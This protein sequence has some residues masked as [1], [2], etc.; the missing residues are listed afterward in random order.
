MIVK[1]G[2][3]N[4]LTYTFNA[5]AKTISATGLNLG[6]VT[7]IRNVTRGN[8]EMKG[9]QT[10]TIVLYGVYT[11]SFSE[12][13]IDSLNTDIID[14]MLYVDGDSEDYSDTDVL[15]NKSWSSQKIQSELLEI[16]E[17]AVHITGA[18]TI[19]GAKTFSDNVTMNGSLSGTSLS[20]SSSGTFIGTVRVKDIR[21][22]LVLE[23]DSQTSTFGYI[24][25]SPDGVRYYTGAGTHFF[26]QP[27]YAG[28]GGGTLYNSPSL[29]IRAN[30]ATPNIPLQV[31]SDIGGRILRLQTYDYNNSDTG[32][33]LRANFGAPTGNTH[34]TLQ[35]YNA[36]ESL[37][38][39]LALNPSGGNVGIGIITPAYPL[40]V[41]G[42]LGAG[43][44]VLSGSLAQKSTGTAWSNP[45]D[46]RLKDNIRDYQKGTEELMKVQVREWEYNGKGGTVL[47]TRGLGV[48]ADD[49][50]KVLP[51]TVDTYDAKLNETDEKTTAIKK[52]DASEITWLLVK[53]VQEQQAIITGLEKR[54]EAL[55]LPLK[56]KI[57]GIYTWIKSLMSTI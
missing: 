49:V 14:I 13:P 40:Q 51:N 38:G 15:F 11:L 36:G 43:G 31:S 16:A 12:V 28:T 57:N 22:T 54:I 39:I 23:D 32:S 47:G 1:I 20:M 30:Q 42:S 8:V 10:G 44:I 50:M 2:V 27:I 55:E 35:S 53:T 33:S 7:S 29:Y 45:S 19:A 37:V 46:S 48:I 17:D 18:E 21:P 41:N 4:A 3:N 26:E 5:V 56:D 24:Q 52:F 25:G 9:F 34:A 6:N